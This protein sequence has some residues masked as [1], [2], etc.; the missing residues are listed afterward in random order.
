MRKQVVV[1]GKVQGVFYRAFTEKEANRLNLQ[2]Y[3]ENRP[4]G[5]VYIDIQGNEGP[6]DALVQWCK[7]GS[8]LA[9][10]TRVEV[11]A[12]DLPHSNFPD[13]FYVKR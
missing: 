5:T 6:V 11:I 2:G 7:T 9:S 8:P 4:D 10:V 1:H 12:D 13:A 3:V